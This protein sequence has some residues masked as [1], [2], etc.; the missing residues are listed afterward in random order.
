M[1][2]N[3]D[4][5]LMALLAGLERIEHDIY[6]IQNWSSGLGTSASWS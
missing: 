6:Y 4:G 3:E 2:R 5:W 1:F